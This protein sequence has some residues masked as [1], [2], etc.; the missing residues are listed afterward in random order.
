MSGL[1]L[2]IEQR[3]SPTRAALITEQRVGVNVFTLIK[4]S[5]PRLMI[6]VDLLNP[7]DLSSHRSKF[8]AVV[9]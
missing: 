1:S 3:Q 9:A 5:E 2:T 6:C 4:P 7:L 8:S